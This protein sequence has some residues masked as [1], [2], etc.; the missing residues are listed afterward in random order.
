[1]NAKRKQIL[2]LLYD[3]PY[4]V[5]H[6][7]GFRDLTELHNGWLREMLYG[8]GDITILAHRGS[9]KTTTLS[10]FLALNTVMFP[11]RTVLFFRKTDTDVAEVIAQTGKLL[12]TGV[13]RK[14]VRTLYGVELDLTRCTASAIDTNLNLSVKGQ[15]Q[16]LGLGIGTSIT[17]KHSEIVVTDDIVNLADRE[18]AAERE[19]TISRYMELQNVKNR[20]GRFINMGTPWHRDDAISLMPNVLR[21]DC[22]S[23]GLLTKE[24]IHDLQRK[25]TPSLFA[26]NYELKHIADKESL[27]TTPQYESDVEKIYDGICHIDA[28]YGG[29]DSTAFTIIKENDG[30]FYVLG[31]KFD[32]HVEDCLDEIC[33]LRERYL[34]GTIWCE[35]NADKGY[36][37]ASLE[38]R[39]EIVQTYH[40]SMNKFVKISTYLKS[41][42]EDIRFLE[43]TDPEYI[44]QILDYS[45]YAA[46]DDSPDSLA[47]ALRQI[48]E[49]LEI[50][51]LPGGII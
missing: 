15:P 51:L 30:L 24:Q 23:T 37:A 47:S 19:K 7:C 5:G 11:R 22:Y 12:Q 50:Q 32:C 4:K 20:G 2:D 18:S 42:W 17:G 21:Y 29:K 33:S 1:M 8:E 38:E 28:S 13:F 39:G 36:L 34:G 45:E 6:W 43:D 44:Q 49:G 46:H 3:E 41:A 25:M 9:Y 35:T 14:I 31:K 10:L 40:E 27:F 26:A 48:D 16:V